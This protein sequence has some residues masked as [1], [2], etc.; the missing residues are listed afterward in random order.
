MAKGAFMPARTFG[1]PQ[2]TCS[3]SRPVATWQS[4]RL[5]AFGWRTTESTSPTI[6]PGSGGAAGVTD[7]TSSPAIVSR[8]A[9]SREIW[10]RATFPVRNVAP[11]HI[12]GPRSSR[13]HARLT[14]IVRA[15][16]ELP[17]EAQVVLEHQAQ[18]VDAVAQHRDPFDAHAEG[19]P[20]VALRIDAYVC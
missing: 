18:V 10:L 3:V 13:S 2:T 19:V 1:A 4:V 12:S 20:R 11:S 8:A 17:Q 16:G 7:S 15:S 6:T 5:S 9:R 14:C